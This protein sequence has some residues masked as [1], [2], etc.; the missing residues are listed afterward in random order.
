MPTYT[1]VSVPAS[2]AGSMPASSRASTAIS[3][4][5][6]CCG[7]ICAASRGEIPK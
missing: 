3:S 5:S 1:A 4:S 2:G 7:S 6:R